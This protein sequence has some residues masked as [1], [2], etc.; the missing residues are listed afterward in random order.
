MHTRISL[1]L[2]VGLL[3]ATSAEAGWRAGTPQAAEAVQEPRIAAVLAR[4]MA[5]DQAILAHD[6][7]AFTGFFTEDAVVNNPF[8]KVARKADAERNMR[9]GLIDYTS[10][11]RTIDYAALRGAHEVV[12]MGE[13]VLTPVRKAKFAGKTVRRR[14]TEVWTDVS[15]EWKLAIRQATIYAAD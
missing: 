12:L 8:N 6:A 3:W 9:T 5:M 13:E 1:M 15:G 2:A 14:I 11:E 4:A 7:A 10:L